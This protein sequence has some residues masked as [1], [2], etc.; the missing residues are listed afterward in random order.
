MLCYSDLAANVESVWN[1]LKP[2]E[3]ISV[4]SEENVVESTHSNDELINFDPC[5]SPDQADSSLSN[6][7][8]LS[9]LCV[10]PSVPLD[11]NCSETESAVSTSVENL[12]LQSVVSHSE[13]SPTHN[14]PV[15]K[16][17]PI[18]TLDS[19]EHNE[20]GFTLYDTTDLSYPC[21][22]EGVDKAD[23][24]YQ[25][26]QEN[27][28]NIDPSYSSTNESVAN[29]DL[30]MIGLLDNVSQMNAIKRLGKIEKGDY[31]YQAASQFSLA[32]QCEA[33]ANYHMAFNYYKS[34][35]GIL[36]T[37]VQSK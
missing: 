31:I 37:G 17:E 1:Y 5:C 28:A 13:L 6:F 9:Q 4:C 22:K 30:S 26:V 32:Q 12:D 36:L 29:I 19:I 23:L 3:E 21:V 24:L 34:G 20:H 25:N 11:A 15:N 2:D 16:D 14:T 33:N 27:I 7:A 8:L 18:L 35:V 10:E